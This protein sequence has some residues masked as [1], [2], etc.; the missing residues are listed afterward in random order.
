M[1]NSNQNNKSYIH[2][3]HSFC[4]TF[5][6]PFSFYFFERVYV[7][8]V[9]FFFCALFSTEKL[10]QHSKTKRYLSL[11]RIQWFC[12]CVVAYLIFFFCDAVEE[13]AYLVPNYYQV[14]SKCNKTR[15]EKKNVCVKI[16]S[17]CQFSEKL[18]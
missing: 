8:S 2:L 9:C 12:L 13:K 4:F 3:N 16:P 15:N 1:Q 17:R 6:L 11:G 7:S 14:N 18:V 10:Q 5:M